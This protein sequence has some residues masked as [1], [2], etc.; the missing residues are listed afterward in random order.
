MPLLSHYTGR[1]G[2]EGIAQSKTL[3]AF[4]FLD[5]NDRSEL[6]YG[7]VELVKRGLRDAHAEASKLLKPEERVDFDPEQAAPKIAAAFR[8][9]YQ[10]GPRE[11]EHLFVTSFARARDSDE[12]DRGILIIW[13]RY[14][15]DG[16]YCLQYEEEE[17]R[18]RVVLEAMRKHYAFAH[19]ATVQYGV[20]ESDPEYSELL[21]QQTQQ[22]LAQVRE[23]KAEMGVMVHDDLMWLQTQF[24]LRMMMYCSKHKDPFYKDE[25]E[26]RVMAVPARL[27]SAEPGIGLLTVKEIKVT[28]T[29]R[30]YIDIGAGLT[31]GLEPVRIIVGPRASP[32]IDDVL[33]R[34]ARKPIVLRPSFPIR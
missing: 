34:F 29:G 3:W 16:G 6:E 11:S 27:P 31:P 22:L 28:P 5:L 33:A 21:F 25:R 1:A 24:V 7:Y 12:E 14:C 30:R 32:D 23:A 15:R 13:D 9:G 17:V 10:A 18:R 19:L 8:A 26:V 4:S 20:D 2:L